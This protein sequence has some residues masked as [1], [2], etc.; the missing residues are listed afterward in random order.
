MTSR[1][2][3]PPRRIT[4]AKGTSQTSIAPS[5][6]RR[7]IDAVHYLDKSKMGRPPLAPSGPLGRVLQIRLSDDEREAFQRAA[8]EAGVT[9]SAWIRDRLS[10]AAKREG[11][12]L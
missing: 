10:K 6:G 11:R 8:D 1:R 2:S 4:P 9:L 3:S 7:R 12:K 5:R